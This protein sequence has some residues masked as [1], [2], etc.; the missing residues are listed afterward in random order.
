MAGSNEDAW[1][2]NNRLV[3][4]LLP[5]ITMRKKS[6]AYLFMLTVFKSSCATFFSSW[7]LVCVIRFDTSLLKASTARAEF[8]AFA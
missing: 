8:Y 3:G 7:Q 6:Q 5:E 2:H 1:Y 4:L